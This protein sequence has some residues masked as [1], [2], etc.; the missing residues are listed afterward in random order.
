MVNERRN[1]RQVT[2]IISNVERRCE[3]WQNGV[4]VTNQ[5]KNG[6][7]GMNEAVRRQRYGRCRCVVVAA[8]E[9]GVTY[10]VV[11]R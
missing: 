5:V 2:S 10:N 9:C 3:V 7:N 4:Q 8:G 6:E 11:N 1:R